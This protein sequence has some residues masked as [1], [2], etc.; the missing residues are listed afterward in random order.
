MF[1]PIGTGGLGHL[2]PDAID[3]FDVSRGCGIHPRSGGIDHGQLVI[4]VHDREYTPMGLL[5]GERGM[6][7]KERLLSVIPAAK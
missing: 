1:E 5:G 6:D 7:V 2:K 4:A 3:C